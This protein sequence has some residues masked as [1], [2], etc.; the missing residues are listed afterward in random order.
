MDELFFSQS[1]YFRKQGEG[2]LGA[3]LKRLNWKKTTEQKKDT[4]NAQAKHGK[5]QYVIFKE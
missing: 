3:I 4:T 5:H 1:T 2:G